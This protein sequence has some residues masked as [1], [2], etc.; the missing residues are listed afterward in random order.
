MGIFFLGRF[1]SE[2]DYFI[3]IENL[4][5]PGILARRK[6]QNRKSF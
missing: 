1:L 6:F 4:V 3:G 5:D 2:L